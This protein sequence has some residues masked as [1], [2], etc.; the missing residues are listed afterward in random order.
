LLNKPNIW[1]NL[2]KKALNR[3]NKH[4]KRLHRSI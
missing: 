3:P 1:L 4:L 2:K